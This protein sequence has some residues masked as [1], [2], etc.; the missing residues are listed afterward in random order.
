VVFATAEFMADFA[1]PGPRGRHLG[2][3][4][5]PA[6]E[7][8]HEHRATLTN[9]TFELAYWAWALRVAARWRAALGLPPE[10]AWERAAA[11][12]APPLVRHGRYAA[13]DVPPYERPDDHPSMLYALGVVPPT[14]MIDPDVMRA[15]LRHVRAHW[16]WDT[17][18]GWDYPAMAMTAARLGDPAADV[19][20]LLMPTAKNTYLPNGHNPQGPGLPAYLPGNGGLLT[21]V[22]LMARGSDA[23][24][25]RPTPGFPADGDWVVR[26]EGLCPLP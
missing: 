16:R 22:A 12:L 2:P 17:T 6:Q 3:P 11:D 13:V 21:A 4:L 24:A 19:D 14:G 18:W 26:H 25:D 7:S 15:T 9:P 1:V 10:Q 8:Y 20:L 23:D 5:V